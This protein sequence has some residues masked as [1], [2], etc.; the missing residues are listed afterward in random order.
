MG[1]RDRVGEQHERL[2]TEIKQVERS[3]AAA[4]A[5][6][7]SLRS[8]LRDLRTDRDEMRSWLDRQP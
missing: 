8:Q 5:E 2:L 7:E 3:L 6:V 4:E 1:M